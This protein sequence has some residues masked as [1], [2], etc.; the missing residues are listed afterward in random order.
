MIDSGYADEAGLAATVV[1]ADGVKFLCVS[2]E[3][4]TLA[5]GDPPVKE[6]SDS[7]DKLENLTVKSGLFKKSVSFTHNGKDYALTVK[8]GKNVVE[9]FKL[10]G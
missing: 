6:F 7:I 5:A 3:V 10:I 2:G 8:D 9:Y 1:C 4:V